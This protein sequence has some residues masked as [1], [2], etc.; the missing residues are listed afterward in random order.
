M[1]IYL[2]WQYLLNMVFASLIV[3]DFIP[4]GAQPIE[5]HRDR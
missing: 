5:C 3:N 1:Y 2:P 4:Y